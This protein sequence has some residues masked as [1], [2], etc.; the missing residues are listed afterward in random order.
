LNRIESNHRIIESKVAVHLDGHVDTPRPTKT[1]AVAPDN[2]VRI[3]DETL[4]PRGDFTTAAATFVRLLLRLR[5]AA[6]EGAMDLHES[7]RGSL[8]RGALDAIRLGVM[9]DDATRVYLGLPKGDNID[10][11]A[12]EKRRGAAISPASTLAQSSADESAS[13]SELD[14][15]SQSL[16]EPPFSASSVSLHAR[17]VDWSAVLMELEALVGALNDAGH[18]AAVVGGWSALALM[19]VRCEVRLGR[20]ARAARMASEALTTWVATG[21]GGEAIYGAASSGGDYSP[22]GEDSNVGGA[23]GRELGRWVRGTPRMMMVQVGAAAAATLG[24]MDKLKKYYQ[25]VLRAD[26]DQPEVSAQYRALKKMLKLLHSAQDLE[27]KGYS[28]KALGILD[29]ALGAMQALQLTSGTFRSGVLLQLCTLNSRIKRHEEAL[30][31]CDQAIGLREDG[32]GST[33]GIG[34]ASSGVGNSLNPKSRSFSD[35]AA[36]RE[37]FVTRA[38][39]EGRDNDH[40]GAVR[41][42]ARALESAE[43]SGAEYEAIQSLRQRLHEANHAKELWRQRR[44]H[45]AT[46]ELPTNLG[47][48]SPVKQCT[49]VKKQHRKLARKWHPDKYR[50]NKERAARK[51]SEVTEAKVELSRRFGC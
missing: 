46:L 49:W 17:P 36:L 2:A 26:P 7:M 33:G 35:P 6:E 9:A 12:H 47:Q 28:H 32:G 22:D 25:L 1:W 48:L 30:A 19:R 5:G 43:V 15:E 3:A 51:M 29:E 14:F 50:G 37:A 4:L 8:E 40:D 44:D 10:D 21:G 16:S 13:D 11:A 45:L 24:D 42:F 23:G 39:A 27:K 18:R 31:H 41:D 34:A 38:E 20:P